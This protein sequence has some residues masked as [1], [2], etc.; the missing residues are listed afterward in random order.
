M[1][2]Y[3][4]KISHFI[5]CFTTAVNE[6]M[7]TETEKTKEGLK[8]IGQFKNKLCELDYTSTSTNTDTITNITIIQNNETER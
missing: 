6:F 5:V 8:S 4:K 3:E 2:K 7:A 1:P